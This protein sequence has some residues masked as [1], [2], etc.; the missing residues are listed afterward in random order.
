MHRD[1]LRAELHKRQVP[2]HSSWTVPE[3][4]AV[5]METRAQDPNSQKITNPMKGIS[6]MNLSELTQMARDAHIELPSKPTRGWLILA[7]R[8]ARS[9]SGETVVPF[10]KFKGWMYREIP[11]G[12]RSWA[13]AEVETVGEAAAHPDLVR[14]ATWAKDNLE[15]TEEA[16]KQTKSL[17][18][19]PEAAAKVPVPKLSDLGYRS[20]GSDWSKVSSCPAPRRARNRRAQQDVEEQSSDMEEEEKGTAEQIEALEKRIAALKKKAAT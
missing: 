13:I 10:G 18:K 8:Q 9:T 4:R 2:F 7:L 19:D 20:S 5:L 12:Y 6:K 3:L 17:A 1:E 11:L 14:L 15:T 16:A